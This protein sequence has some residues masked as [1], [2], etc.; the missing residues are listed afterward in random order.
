[1]NNKILI[2]FLALTVILVTVYL[3]ISTFYETSLKESSGITGLTPPVSFNQIRSSR[4][5]IRKSSS[6]YQMENINMQTPPSSMA[7]HSQ[8]T[9]RQIGVVGEN[10]GSN[11]SS[12]QSA[13]G[14]MQSGY[15]TSSGIGVNSK[16]IPRTSG[17]SFS[18]TLSPGVIGK[19]S[20]KSSAEYSSGSIA[21]NGTKSSS[22]SSYVPFSEGGSTGTPDPGGN[23]DDSC[24][25]DIVFIPVP[26][27]LPFLIFLSLAYAL[28]ILFRVKKNKQRLSI[29]T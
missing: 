9:K 13:T 27:G 4:P 2:S 16:P 14:S 26:D 25:D 18:S 11:I 15:S 29:K 21:F 24:E 3:T 10:I 23:V 20:N 7:L 6:T 8:S 12:S 17:G 22:Q 28:L 1:M 5:Q 19:T